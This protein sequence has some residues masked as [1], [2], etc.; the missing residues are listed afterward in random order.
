MAARPL[1]LNPLALLVI[2]LHEASEQLQDLGEHSFSPP[3]ELDDPIGASEYLEKFRSWSAS[4]VVWLELQGR[5]ADAGEIDD[6]VSTMLGVAREYDDGELLTIPPAHEMAEHIEPFD[7]L[8]RAV[9]IATGRLEDLL[10]EVP[11]GVWEGYDDA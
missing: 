11:A 3:T 1:N 4:L 2:D 5:S 8:L 10:E 6:S 7:Q 9:D